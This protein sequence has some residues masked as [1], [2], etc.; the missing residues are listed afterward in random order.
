[1]SEDDIRKL[2]KPPPYLDHAF[3]PVVRAIYEDGY[4]GAIPIIEKTDNPKAALE[5]PDFRSRFYRAA[6]GGFARAQEEVAKRILALESNGLNTTQTKREALVLRSLMDGVAWQMISGQLYIARRLFRGG[7]PPRLSQSNFESVQAAAIETFDEETAR[8]ALISDLTTFVQLGDLLIIDPLKGGL[9]FVEV[10]SGSKNLKI[11]EFLHSLPDEPCGYKAFLEFQHNEG[12]KTVEQLD[13]V[14]R[15]AKRLSDAQE[16]LATGEGFDESL[17][18]TVHIPEASVDIA[19]YNHR[20]SAAIDKSQER[21]W[22]IDVI[23]DDCLFIGAYRD[24]MLGAGLHMFAGWFQSCEAPKGSPVHGLLSCIGSPLA[25]PLFS[26]LP[27]DQVCDLLFGRCIVVVGLHLDNFVK[28]AE[29]R[30]ISTRWSSRRDAE[31]PQFRHAYK[32]DHRALIFS[33]GEIELILSD[34]LLMR[35]MCHGVTPSSALD[36]IE[37]QLKNAGTVFAQSSTSSEKNIP[38]P[39]ADKDLG[40]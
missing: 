24:I 9:S 15:Q 25:L 4:R 1:M 30:G 8:F 11:M 7:R 40:G 22:A 28:F 39:A 38:G 34:G 21:G 29:K 27:I 19:H 12:A 16:L 35:M 18:A 20:L 3:E 33:R 14:L 2:P 32:V 6:H 23:D 26:R 37:S 10:K 31:K 5:D 36:L 17:G 13:R